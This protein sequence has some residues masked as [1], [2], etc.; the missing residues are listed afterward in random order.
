MTNRLQTIML[1]SETA[2]PGPA[3]LAVISLYLLMG[4]IGAG[5]LLTLLTRA[6]L[7]LPR[8][9]RRAGVIANRPW[10]ARDLGILLGVI[11]FGI[12][13]LVA[14]L[15][16]GGNGGAP[17]R[18]HLLLYES[19]VIHGGTLLAVLLLVR[20]RGLRWRAAFGFRREDLGRQ[21]AVGVIVY[22]AALPLLFAA[23][24]LVQLLAA[25][26]DIPVQ[27]QDVIRAIQSAQSPWVLGY[28]M[29]LGIVQGP[30]VEELLFRGVLLPVVARRVGMGPA[31]IVVSVIFAMLHN[32]ALAAAPLF[33][34]GAAFCV[35][36]LYTGSLLTP[37]LMHGL[38]NAVNLLLLFTAA[39]S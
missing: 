39:P 35:G 28:F 14:L 11:V 5:I 26:Y 21:C 16:P 17:P 23:A 36:Y 31:I 27:P 8:I 3:A 33:I 13:L 37:I 7:Y 1:S 19:L 2:Q 34:I 22:L 29:F 24:L 9:R 20:M 15:R 32:H 38:F 25:V 18:P 30:L 4:L 10:R 6:S 12:G